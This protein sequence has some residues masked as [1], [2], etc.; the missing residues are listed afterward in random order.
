MRYL[1]HDIREDVRRKWHG[2]QG[3]G[4]K[5]WDTWKEA[6]NNWK[7]DPNN[8]KYK[9]AERDLSYEELVLSYLYPRLDA[10]VSTGINHLLKSP[11]CVHP[12][13]GNICVPFDPANVQNFKL[14]EVPTLTMVINELGSVQK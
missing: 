10:N 3:D 9:V 1:S 12:K 5:M 14:S 2:M 8:A 13:T 4:K 6:H 7:N 11:F